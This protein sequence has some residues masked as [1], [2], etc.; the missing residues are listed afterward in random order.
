[1]KKF[2]TPEGAIS[3]IIDLLFWPLV[4]TVRLVKKLF[5]WS[6]KDAPAFSIG[7]FVVETFGKIVAWFKK[8]PARI[9]LTIREFTTAAIAGMKLDFMDLVDVLKS[10][11]AKIKLY[12]QS[13]LPFGFGISDA[14]YERQLAEL[15][16][17]DEKRLAERQ[18]IV[19]ELRKDLSNIR[20][21]REALNAPSSVDNSTNSNTTILTPP[22]NVE[23]LSR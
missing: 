8:L 11:P 6:D 14:E 18:A 21:E 20:S 7:D 2:S 12:A 23:V 5:G 3:G 16:K 1:M 4:A 19:E 9:M 15:S 13:L 17:P 22:G 10:I